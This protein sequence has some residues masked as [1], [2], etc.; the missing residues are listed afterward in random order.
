M[1]IEFAPDAQF[2]LRQIG[3]YTRDTWGERQERKYLLQI[4]ATVEALGNGKLKGKPVQ[5]DYRE[6]FRELAGKHYVYFERRR[7]LIFILR[8]LH[9]SMQMDTHRF[10]GY[11]GRSSEG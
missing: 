11:P 9:G 6:F 10:P 2:D 7:D 1:R 8:I 5:T 3:F 4:V